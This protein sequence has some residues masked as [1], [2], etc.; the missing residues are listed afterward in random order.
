MDTSSDSGGSRSP[1]VYGP[2]AYATSYDDPSST[3]IVKSPSRYSESSG[4][5]AGSVDEPCTK[6]HHKFSIDRILGRFGGGGNTAVVTTAV[7][8]CPEAPGTDKSHGNELTSRGAATG[9]CA[10]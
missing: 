1:E 5:G 2:V 4:S 8:S 10:L 9:E 7:N 6:A 3:V